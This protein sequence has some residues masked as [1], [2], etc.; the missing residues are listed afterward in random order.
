[1]DD[2]DVATSNGEF[3]A[4]EF[5]VLIG[6]PSTCGRTL[7]KSR[8]QDTMFPQSFVLQMY[9]SDHLWLTISHVVSS[10]GKK[11][12]ENYTR[13][14]VIYGTEPELNK[15]GSL[16]VKQLKNEKW[17]SPKK[18]DLMQKWMVGKGFLS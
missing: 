1:M 13:S 4:Q 12:R 11:Q 18:T 3:E 14:R 8:R 9:H 16:Q 2:I 6:A 5:A 15:L 10:W 7:D 17:K